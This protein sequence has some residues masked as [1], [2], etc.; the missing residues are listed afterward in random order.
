[1]NNYRWE[2]PV[3]TGMDE[4]GPTVDERTHAPDPAAVEAFERWRRERQV[5]KS[6]PADADARRRGGKYIV[7]N[8]M[9]RAAELERMKLPDEARLRELHREH[10]AGATVAELAKPLGLSHQ[11]LAAE[12]RNL[13]LEVA[14]FGRARRGQGATS[15]PEGAH[16]QAAA[17]RARDPGRGDTYRNTD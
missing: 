6:R 3:R 2:N 4:D 17:T 11:R 12:W 1:M 9:R 7:A 10:L 8:L 13:G 16:P 5:A 14:Q 15:E